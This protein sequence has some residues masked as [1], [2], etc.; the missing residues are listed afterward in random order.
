MGNKKRVFLG[1]TLPEETKSEISCR[2]QSIYQSCQHELRLVPPRNYHVTLHFLGDVATD[3]VNLLRDQLPEVLSSSVSFEGMITKPRWFASRGVPRVFWCGVSAEAAGRL[4]QSIGSWL[5]ANGFPVEERAYRP[6]VT[7]ARSRT[8]RT[9]R[10][11]TLVEELKWAPLPTVFSQVV[12]FES[13]LG[14]GPPLYVP[15]TTV[16]LGGQK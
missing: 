3:E 1:L 13:K 8:R 14:K 7:W 6:H 10:T 4:H 11:C 12:L 15:L 2:L 16:E 5:K 9:H